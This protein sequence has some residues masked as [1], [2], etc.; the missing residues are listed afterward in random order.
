MG[1]NVAGVVFGC[2]VLNFVVAVSVNDRMADVSHDSYS[3]IPNV[4]LVSQQ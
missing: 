1:T 3:A 4:S 2:L